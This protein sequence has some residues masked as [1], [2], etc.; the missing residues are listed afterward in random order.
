MIAYLV[1]LQVVWAKMNPNQ[2]KLV[3]FIQHWCGEWEPP[4]EKHPSS[5]IGSTTPKYTYSPYLISVTV[6]GLWSTKKKVNGCVNPVNDQMFGVKKEAIFA[7]DVCCFGKISNKNY[8]FTKSKNNLWFLLQNVTKISWECH[9]YWQRTNK[10]ALIFVYTNN[11]H[12]HKTSQE[13][14]IL[15]PQVTWKVKF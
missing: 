3:R 7:C 13:L 14:R 10:Q 4:G 15:P 12:I 6:S 1:K 2:E 5:Y 8:V 11:T 9:Q